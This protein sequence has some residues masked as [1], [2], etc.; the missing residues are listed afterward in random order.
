MEAAQSTRTRDNVAH[1]RVNHH[2]LLLGYWNILTLT[3]KELEL[4]EEA[5]RYHLVLSE[6]LQPD[7]VAL[8]LWILMADGNSSILVPILISLLKQVWGFSQAPICQTVCQIGFLW[9]HGSV[10]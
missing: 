6:Y 2:Q 1:S 10:C 4:V 3:G 9:D 8:E 7:D 5:K